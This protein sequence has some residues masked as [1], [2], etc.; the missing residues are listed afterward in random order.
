MKEKTIRKGPA[1]I[2]RQEILQD[3]TLFTSTTKARF[4]DKFFDNIDLSCFPD[5]TDET[6]WTLDCFI[7]DGIEQYLKDLMKSQVLN[8]AETGII[9]TLFIALDRQ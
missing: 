7:N 3:I 4:Y 9:D 5:N 1:L 2:Y 8:L 6:G